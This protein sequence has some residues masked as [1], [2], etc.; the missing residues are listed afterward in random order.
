MKRHIVAACAA[1][2]MFSGAVPLAA[3]AQ[4]TTPVMQPDTPATPL[5]TPIPALS[6]E[7]AEAPGSDDPADAKDAA[8]MGP[9]GQYG[10][11][12]CGLWQNGQWVGNTRC[13]GYLVG[14]HRAK[15]DGTIIAVKGHLV[16]VQMSEK[17]IVINDAPALQRET[18]G[19]V[20]VGRQITAYGYWSSG[21]FYATRLV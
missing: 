13:P 7:A 16:T 4:T 18:S 8:A 6:P 11:P 19:K 12:V 3:Y 9:S 21:T 10:D 15:V 17:T 1:L 20:A 2:A 5:A 14:P